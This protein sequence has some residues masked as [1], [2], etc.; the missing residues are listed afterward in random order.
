MCVSWGM[1]KSMCRK[2]KR[3]CAEVEKADVQVGTLPASTGT[4]LRFTGSSSAVAPQWPLE[5][6]KNASSSAVASL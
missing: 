4:T 2:C 5:I 1:Q 6:V 3:V